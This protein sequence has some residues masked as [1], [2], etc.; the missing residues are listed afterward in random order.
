[1]KRRS[2]IVEIT[3]R[4]PVGA[5]QSVRADF[6]EGR[7]AARNG[8]AETRD[9]FA[10]SLGT[11]ARQHSYQAIGGLGFA[12][13]NTYYALRYGS[14]FIAAEAAYDGLYGCVSGIVAYTQAHLAKVV[15]N[16]PVSA[17]STSAETPPASEVPSYNRNPTAVENLTVVA[18]QLAFFA[19]IAMPSLA[20][21]LHLIADTVTR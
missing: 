18:G 6:L 21:G 15:R 7:D 17:V 9:R 16:E 19:T 13:V 10:N 1:M 5:R 20:E 8:D 14:G 11:L 2:T 12:A 4:I 3:G